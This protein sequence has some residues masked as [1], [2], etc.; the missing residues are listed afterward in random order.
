LSEPVIAVFAGGTSAE[1]EVSLG[2]GS[3][4]RG[5]P[6]ALLHDTALP[7]AAD[8]F[9]RATIPRA[10]SFSRPCTAP[11]ART[12]ACSAPGRGGRAYAGCDAAASALTMDK[13][14]TKEMVAARACGWPTRLVFDARIPAVG[15][16]GRARRLGVRGGAK[17]QQPG[18]QRRA[19]RV[20]QTW[21]GWRRRSAAVGRGRWLAERRID[22]RELS[23]GILGGSGD[24][25]RGDYAPTRA[26][27]TTRASTPRG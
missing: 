2:L 10:M 7:I 26:S 19:E 25:R 8:A 6:G 14:L 5:G 21:R 15:G 9:P 1:R 13:A 24:G 17:T 3:G 16:R 20:F 27:T 18:Q 4:V 11:L 23:V 22:G 12:G